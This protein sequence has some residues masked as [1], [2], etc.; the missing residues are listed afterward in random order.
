MQPWVCFMKIRILLSLLLGLGGALLHAAEGPLRVFIRAG[1]KTHG[2]GQH[3]HPR[4]LGDYTAL[5]GERGVKVEGAMNFPAPKQLENTDVL[6]VFAADG[7]KIEGEQR[8]QFERFLRRGGGLVVI[9]DGV[10]S[11]DQNDWAKKVQGGSWVWENRRTKWYEGEVG[12]Y[13]VNPNHPISKGASNFDWKDEIYYDLDMAPDVTVLATSFHSVF[14][15]AP[16]MWTYEKT[17]EGGSTPYRAFVSL[18]GHEH[19]SFQTPHYRALLLRGIAWAGKR[20]DA[21]EFCKPEELASLKYPEGGPLKPEKAASKLSVH[22]EFDI[23]L[24]TSEPLVEKVMSVDW[25]PAGRLWVVE[26][27]EY[28]NGRTINKNDKPIALWNVNNPDGIRAGDKED[29][30]GRDRVSWLED[31]DGD[32]RMDKKHVFVD[33]LE[34]ATSFVFYKDGVI[35]AQAP[36][37]LWARDTDGD[38]K[39]DKV[40]KLYTGFGTFDTHAVMNNFRWGLDGW[41]YGA[42]GY[43]AGQPKSGNGTRDFGRI[44]AGVFRFK[45]DGSAVEQYASG[46]CNTWG[47]DFSAEGEAFYSTATCG[48]HLLHIVMPEKVLARASVGGIRASVVIPDHQ[49]VFPAVHHNRP[50][51]VQIDWVGMFTAASGCCLYNGGAWPER[52][53][54]MQFLSEPTV[55]LVHNEILKPNG[56]SFT[57]SKESGREEAEFIAGSDLWFRPIHTRV[58]PDGALYVVDFYNQ[59][60]IHNDTRGPAHGARNAAT[61]PDR[62]HHFTRVWR[63]QHKQAKALETKSMPVKNALALIRILGSTPNGWARDT[64]ARLLRES[65]SDVTELA[66]VVK[67]TT[68]SGPARIAA[69][70]TMD[71]RGGLDN[72]LLLAAIKDKNPVV[73]RNALKIASEHDNSGVSPEMDDVRA[74]LNNPDA[75]VRLNTLITLATCALNSEVAAG[76]VAAWPQFEDKHIQSAA[77][78]VA[79]KDPLMFLQAS[80][81]AADPAF[82]ADFVGHLA[83][84]AGNTGDANLAARMVVLSARQPAKTE[85]L[86]QAIL[87]T[88]AGSLPA[89]NLPGWT[90][91]LQAAFKALLR[92]D[93]PGL[94][95][96]TLPLIARWDSE[97]TLAEDLK[98]AITSLNAKLQD[99]GLPDDQR[100]QVAIN[101]L[102]VH[103]ID[104]AI[105]PSVAKLL[106]ANSSATLQRRVIEGLGSTGAESAATALIR[107]YPEVAN[108]LREVV[109]GQLIKRTES[110]LAL[111]QSMAEKK[112][113]PLLVGPSNLHRLRTH[114][115]KRVSAKA[116]EVI[117]ALRGPEQKQK[118][119]LIAQWKPLVEKAGG[120]LENGKKL[121]T[122]NCAGC[123]VFKNEGRDL[124][125]NLTGMGAHGAAELL[126]HVVDPNKVVEPNFVSTS[127]ETNDDLTYDG[128]VARENNAEIVL[129][130]A[131]ADFTIRK[132]NIKSR[133]SSGRSLMPEGFEALGVEGM[134]DMLAYI[135]ADENRFRILDM[136]S[137][138]TANTSKGIYV[139]EE[140][141][142]E[143]LRFKKFGTIK[144]GDIPFDILS[145]AKS[146][147][148]NNVLVLRGGSGL[149]RSFAQSV[150]VKAG[151]AATRLH[152]LGGIGGW[153]WPYGGEAAKD[154]PVAKVTVH[155][156]GGSS[157]EMILKNGVEVADYIGKF[158]VPASKEVPDLLV[159]GQ[160]RTFSKP[161]KGRAV[162]EKITLESFNNT[163]APTFVALTLQIGED[164]PGSEVSA[165]IKSVAPLKFQ[166]QGKIKS[167]LVG[168]GSSHDFGRWFNLADVAT[169]NATGKTEALY[170][171]TLSLVEPTLPSTD[172]LV[173]SSNQNM[174]DKALRDGIMAFADS[175]KGLLLVHPGLWYSWK[176]WPEYNR[177]LAGGGSRS[178]DKYGEFEVTVTE[179]GHP[180]MAGAPMKFS[181]RDELYRQEIDPQGSPVQVLATGFEKSTGKTWPV[182]FI[183][184]HPKARIVGITLGHDGM[185][186]DHPAYKQ[187]LSNSV[188]WAGEK[189]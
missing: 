55:S 82:L 112:V 63:V 43:S 26:T 14:V 148:G 15:I 41:V 35:I 78:G 142:D 135:C 189:K 153:A 151:F 116:N 145:P 169:L 87:E 128:V 172:V 187:I 34:L 58:G 185:S 119:E 165:P 109:F 167:L 7:M 73:Q 146:P 125:P 8:V 138:F 137:V 150:E 108:D 171:E 133:R 154:K 69:L 79:I 91:E 184:K 173:W 46:S 48:E 17:W 64:A 129:R 179:P 130:N 147:G 157:E 37:I 49:K 161:I 21:D 90:P 132:N 76:V 42:V 100:S 57:A 155:F 158:E 85:G 60:A 110:A 102:G 70:Y 4:F 176:Q 80:F 164:R 120:N 94:P 13:F 160:V 121:F 52:F 143:T 97:G 62:D 9:H 88:I 47:F 71:A 75:R 183:V 53:N 18:P 27:P 104:A 83:R 181:L 67:D 186:H 118:E 19:T 3:D 25:D 141:K 159:R 72:E 152:F 95:G 59:A 136:T 65:G 188:R 66:D 39:A 77:L 20:P 50:A 103:R 45:P 162:V 123:H 31:T 36:D 111:L 51:Y 106:T 182:I 6:V 61:R 74:L 30:P 156:A 10:V 40:E 101:L 1:V 139:S 166:S 114:G 113:D 93:R 5:L 16:Q 144:V 23:H 84:L 2:P 175:G 140:A 28:P 174:E 89:A 131:T 54:G 149:A 163:V 122:A 11:G 126:V 12:M 124:A 38:G 81:Q 24:V 177:I 33:G 86:K 22:P 96:A 56:V 170:T 178:H 98:P 168:G 180:I 107:S 68:K 115:D 134:R 105:I 99:P 32:G 44:T 92:S 127:L 117:D 29:R